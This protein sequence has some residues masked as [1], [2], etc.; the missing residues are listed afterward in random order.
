MNKLYDVMTLL[1]EHLL[2]AGY[3]IVRRVSTTDHKRTELGFM[4]GVL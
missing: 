3:W 1:N 4:G 2:R